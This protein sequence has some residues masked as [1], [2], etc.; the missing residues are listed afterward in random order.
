MT[1]DLFEGNRKEVTEFGLRA[2]RTEIFNT[3]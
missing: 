1:V 2:G 3:G